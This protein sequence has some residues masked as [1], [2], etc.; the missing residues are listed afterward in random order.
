MIAVESWI[1]YPW[2][3]NELRIPPLASM[4]E[5][6]FT[7]AHTDDPITTARTLNVTHRANSMFPYILPSFTFKFFY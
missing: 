2:Y 7:D 6:E 3:R 4:S 1:L 5:I